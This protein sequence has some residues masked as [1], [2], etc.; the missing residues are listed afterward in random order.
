MEAPVTS[1]SPLWLATACALLG[2]PAAPKGEVF[3]LELVRR[4][5]AGRLPEPTHFEP[6]DRWK[7]LV[8]CPP[9]WRGVAGVVVYQ[10]GKAY[11]PL[12]VQRLEDCGNRR[13]LD[14]AFRLDG[15][16]PA[17]VCARFARNVADWRACATDSLCTFVEPSISR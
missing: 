14:G 6:D 5:R 13:A 1:L 9:A 15:K 3:A 12:S 17:R 7:A 2:L 16:T 11:E 8:T 10:D 4:D